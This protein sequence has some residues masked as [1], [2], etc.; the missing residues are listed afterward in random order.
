MNFYKISDIE[1]GEDVYVNPKHIIFYMRTEDGVLIDI[2]SKQIL[3]LEADF[4][5]M[6]LRGR[7]EEWGRIEE[8]ER[9][10]E[11]WED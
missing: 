8:P 6:M 2:G 5:D 7:I 4:E 9:I 10:E 11:W 3:T 1:T